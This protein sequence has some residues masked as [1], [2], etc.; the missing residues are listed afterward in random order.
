MSDVYRVL[1]GNPG[2]KRQLGKHRRRWEDNIKTDIQEVLFGNMYW[3]DVAQDRVSW[4][5]LMNMVMNTGV[6]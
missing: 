4:T 2:G 6:L 1:V 5:A 3:I